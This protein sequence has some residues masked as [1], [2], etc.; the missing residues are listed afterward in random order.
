MWPPRTEQLRRACGRG[1]RFL[2]CRCPSLMS[3]RS[4][5]DDNAVRTGL[6]LLE[7]LEVVAGN[8]TRRGASLRLWE[9]KESRWRRKTM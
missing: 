4:W 6:E 3:R 7:S 9:E 5:G 8:G 2:S 1:S